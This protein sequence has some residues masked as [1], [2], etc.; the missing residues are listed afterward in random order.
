LREAQ[1]YRASGGS[2]H[3]GRE[4]K[5]LL[6][7]KSGASRVPTSK[8]LAID[9]LATSTVVTSEITALEH[10]I[11]DHTVERGTSIAITVLAGRELPEVSCGFGDDLV[12]Q[13][14]DDSTSRSTVNLDVKL[15]GQGASMSKHAT[16]IDV[17]ERKYVDV[18]GHG[19]FGFGSFDRKMVEMSV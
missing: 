11:G 10:E 16:L 4:G 7:D 2:S 3:L 8:F 19:C 18:V 6:Q 12:V 15:G 9:G 1:A 14:E 13:F 5:E 17:Q